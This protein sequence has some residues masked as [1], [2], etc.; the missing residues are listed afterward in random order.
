VKRILVTG[1]SGYVGG[2]LV[3]ELLAKN[4]TVRVMVRDPQ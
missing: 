4:F 2:R 1:A 3:Q